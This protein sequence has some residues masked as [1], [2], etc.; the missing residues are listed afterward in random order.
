MG[1]VELSLELSLELSWND[2]R[3]ATCGPK[4]GKSWVQDC[5]SILDVGAAI[6]EERLNIATKQGDV[7]GGELVRAIRTI[8]S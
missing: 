8:I 1:W 5:D 7:G 2:T 3:N 6:E 4:R